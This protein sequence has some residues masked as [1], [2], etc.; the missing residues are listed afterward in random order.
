MSIGV[1]GLALSLAQSVGLVEKL[2]DWFGGGRGADVANAVVD[3]ARE[4]TGSFDAR[5]AHDAVLKDPQMLIEFE[6][7]VHARMDEL[8]RL[9]FEDRQNA[10]QA[11]GVA[12]AQEDLFS[13]RFLYYLAAFWSVFTSGYLIAIT[14]VDIPDASQ[15]YA[16][17]I[18]TFLLG[19]I[20]ATMF[21]YFFGSSQG[22]ARKGDQIAGAHLASVGGI[23]AGVS[24]VAK[25]LKQGGYAAPGV[26]LWISGLAMV[27]ALLFAPILAFAGD[28]ALSWTAPT[29]RADGSALSQA[30]VAKYEICGKQVLTF[31]DGGDCP[32]LVSVPGAQTSQ[33]MVGAVPDDGKAAYFRL[34][35]IDTGGAIGAWSNVVEKKLLAPPLGPVLK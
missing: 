4:V 34:R 6:E 5:I 2:G 24:R 33:V 15:R 10:R 22:S 32:S 7:K 9:A 35:A 25:A 12:L 17:G 26:M 30:D 16:D 13:K 8:E 21:N 31:T 14:F 18:F 19:T 11:Q 27:A 20:V 3:V 1:I 29:K 28:A 23:A